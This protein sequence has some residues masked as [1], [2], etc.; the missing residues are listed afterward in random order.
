MNQLYWH[1]SLLRYLDGLFLSSYEYLIKTIFLWALQYS[2]YVNCRLKSKVPVNRYRNST[3]HWWA[4]I[5]LWIFLPSISFVNQ[6]LKGTNIAHLHIYYCTYIFRYKYAKFR[7]NQGEFT[8]AINEINLIADKH[9]WLRGAELYRVEF[10][11]QV[12]PTNKYSDGLHS[13][14][15]WCCLRLVLVYSVRLVSLANA[16]LKNLVD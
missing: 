1:V 5:V 4:F 13:W 7:I 12:K 6:I 15:R 11:A 2:Y 10:S 8:S 9:R 14:G 16:V 3:D